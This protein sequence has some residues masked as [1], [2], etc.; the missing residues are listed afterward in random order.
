MVKQREGGSGETLVVELW[1]AGGQRPKCRGRWDE[2]EGCTAG[3]PSLPDLPLA[4]LAMLGPR[5]RIQ[6]SHIFGGVPSGQLGPNS[7]SL[8]QSG[9]CQSHSGPTQSSLHLG[10]PGQAP[11]KASARE[12]PRKGQIF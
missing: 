2:V 8:E 1:E 11:T 4:A 3:I 6:P 12:L 5:L 10:L 7:G 9:S